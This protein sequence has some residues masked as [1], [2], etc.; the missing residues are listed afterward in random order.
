MAG[1]SFGNLF[2]TALTQILDED[3]DKALDASSKIL[4]VRGRVIPAST[5]NIVLMA[6][7]EDG[8]IVAVKVRFRLC[9]NVLNVFS[10]NLLYRNR[11]VQLCKLSM[12][13]MLLFWDRAACTQVVMPNLL[14]D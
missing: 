8:S 3:V 4:K 2:L 9:K 7:M 10:Q 14:I 1:H 13:R 11:R 6:E 12:K 5:Q